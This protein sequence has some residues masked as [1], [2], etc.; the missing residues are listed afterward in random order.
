M[1]K[2]FAGK[3]SLRNLNSRIERWN[4]ENERNDTTVASAMLLKFCF[5]ISRCKCKRKRASAS[6]PKC[7]WGRQSSCCRS[8]FFLFFVFW[9][10]LLALSINLPAII[11]Q[12]HRIVSPLCVPFAYHGGELKGN[13]ACILPYDDVPPERTDGRS[14]LHNEW[15][16]CFS[17]QRK[18]LLRVSKNYRLTI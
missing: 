6:W 3:V 15:P 7:F 17:S 10:L 12:S 1:R 18:T 8:Y 16:K 4:C 13:D 5:A 2:T 11:M 14:V 9:S